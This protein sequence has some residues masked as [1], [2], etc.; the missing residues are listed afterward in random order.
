MRL[1]ATDAA[2]LY[3]ETASGPMHISSVYVLEGELGFEDFYEH[4]AARIH[5]LPT[6]RQKIAMVPFNVAHPKWIEDPDFDLKNH[7]IHHG[8]PQGASFQEALDFTVV[9]NEPMLE[10]SKPL[11]ADHIVTRLPGVT[12]V[13][14][15]THHCIID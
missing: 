2:F 15:I 4:F 13:L 11:W 9:L 6:Y 7:L 8:L 5:L 3:S 12:M 14:N 1:S 10:R